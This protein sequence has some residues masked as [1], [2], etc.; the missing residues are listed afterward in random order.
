MCEMLFCSSSRW[1]DLIAKLEH[2][3]VCVCECVC[4]LHVLCVYALSVFWVLMQD[5]SC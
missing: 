4:M 1:L 2:V 3:C 5:M